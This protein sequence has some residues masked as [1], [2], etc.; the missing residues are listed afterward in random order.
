[1]SSFSNLG[2]EFRVNTTTSGVQSNSSVAALAGG[3][4]VVVWTTPR[5]VTFDNDIAGQIYDSSGTAV[6]SELT[7]SGAASVRV[8]TGRAC[9]RSARA[10]RRTAGSASMV[11]YT[12]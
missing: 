6:G 12:A 1:M 4:F 2:A 11:K 5:P 8:S 7:L 9:T 10:A 3:G